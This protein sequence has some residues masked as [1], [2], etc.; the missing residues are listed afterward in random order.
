M[1]Q[2]K[3]HVQASA[4][5]RGATPFAASYTYL[6]NHNRYGNSRAVVRPSLTATA[7]TGTTVVNMCSIRE[8]Y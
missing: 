1:D 8:Y 3:K 5:G 7:A 6:Q 2:L 4:T